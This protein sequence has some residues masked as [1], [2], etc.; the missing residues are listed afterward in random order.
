[1]GLK[2]HFIKYKQCN[3]YIFGARRSITGHK[4]LTFESVIKDLLFKRISDSI[5]QDNFKKKKCLK[6]NAVD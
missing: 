3:M 1:M 4:V 2:S 6:G 5:F